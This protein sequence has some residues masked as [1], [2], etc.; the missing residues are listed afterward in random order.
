VTVSTSEF[1]LVRA[2]MSHRSAAQ[3]R[4]WTT[5]DDVGE[6][7]DAFATLGP[8]PTVDLTES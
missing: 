4:A 6:H 8:L 7:L 5:R 3:L 1:D 2:L